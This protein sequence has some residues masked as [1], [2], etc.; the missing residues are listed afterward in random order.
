MAMLSL[1]LT[2][3]NPSNSSTY[4]SKDTS[5][6]GVGNSDSGVISMFMVCKALGLDVA[7]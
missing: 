3:R 5:G 1:K 6:N 7:T 4:G 2:I